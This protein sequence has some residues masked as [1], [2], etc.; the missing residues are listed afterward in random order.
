MRSSS[1]NNRNAIRLLLPAAAVAAGLFLANDTLRAQASWTVRPG[2][3]ILYAAPAKSPQLENAGIWKAPPILISGVSAYRDG[4]FLYQDYLYDDRGAGQRALYPKALKAQTNDNAADF[5]E[6]RIKPT[7]DATAV[8]ITYNTLLDPEVVATT[9]AFGDAV[10]AAAIPFGA[11]GTEP[12]TVF[13][14]VHGQSGVVTDAATGKVLGKATVAVD[15]LRRQVEVRVPYGLFDT[16]GK[17]VRVAAGTGLWETARDAYLAPD[18]PQAPPPPEPGAA[19]GRGNQRPLP[20]L[21][22]GH[23]L[24]FNVAF[25]YHEPVNLN[26]ILPFYNDQ[27]QSDALAN[28]DLSPFFADV[29]FAKLASG[30]TDDSGIPKKGFMNRIVVSHF[31]SAQ[32]RGDAGRLDKSCKQPC[33]PQFAGRLQ[34]YSIY[35]PDKAPPASGYGLTLDLHSASATYARWVGQDRMVEEGERGTGSIVVTPFGRGLTGFYYGQSGADVFE[36]WADVARLYKIDPDYVALTGLSMGAI[37][38][39]K[40]AGQFPDL[41]AAAAVQVGCPFA[42]VMRNHA[43][44]PF[45]LHTGDAD[46]LTNCRPGGAQ[47]LGQWLALNQPYVWRN[48]L[49]QP[50]PFSSIPRNWQ[51]YADFLGVK[52][53]AADPPHVLY[54]VDGDMVEPAFGLNSDHAYWVSHLSLRDMN[55]HLE[56]DSNDPVTRNEEPPA[57]GLVDVFSHGFGKG[58]PVPNPVV[59]T[60]GT[61]DFGVQNYTWPNYDQQEVTWGPAPEIPVSDVIDIKAENIAT[62]AIDPKRAKITCHATIN[63]D[64][65]GPIDVKLFGCSHPKI[66]MKKN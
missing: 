50:H 41:F 49:K 10:S 65:D 46:V 6:L 45:M 30:V 9:L 64:S 26:S 11:S 63:V 13:V 28:G 40:L 38:S 58:D 24:F 32:G 39:F 20:P 2:P 37:G 22:P 33:I 59:K 17:T 48:Y 55:H 31:E 5:V 23:S 53:R 16:R 54:G 61:F 51:P 56:K 66:V 7:K 18:Q 27:A 57:Y 14:T 12:A 19:R 34:P 15:T 35:V 52:K 21:P 1:S 36:V 4:E 42:T 25:R 3:D 44:V 29:D 60:S 47:V 62:V 8:R 43:L